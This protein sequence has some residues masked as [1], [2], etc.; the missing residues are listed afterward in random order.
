MAEELNI[1][2]SIAMGKKAGERVLAVT[3]KFSEDEIK[4]LPH[5]DGFH[6]TRVVTHPDGS[7]EFHYA[8]LDVETLPVHSIDV[9]FANHGADVAELVQAE[10]FD[11]TIRRLGAGA[12]FDH[13]PEPPELLK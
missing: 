8:A 9:V 2:R 7:Q 5:A 11:R 6:M 10:S 1:S 12:V 3:Q 4:D 13:H